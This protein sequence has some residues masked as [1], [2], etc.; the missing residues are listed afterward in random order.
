MTVSA[1]NEAEAEV[2]GIY[3]HR[4]RLLSALFFDATELRNSRDQVKSK[5]TVDVHIGIM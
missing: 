3:I 5:A 2:G 1:I 4:R